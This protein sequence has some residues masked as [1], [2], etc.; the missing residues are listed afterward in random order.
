M[1]SPSTEIENL[2]ERVKAYTVTTLELAKLHTLQTTATVATSLVW[3]L[4]VSIILMLFLL[5]VSTGMALLLGD[6]LGKLYYGFFIVAGF[7]LLAGLVLHFF[8]R[9]WIA[10]PISKLIITEALQEL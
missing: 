3:R 10:N 4:S 8:L 1:L 6:L 5:L 9:S 2:I 7:Y